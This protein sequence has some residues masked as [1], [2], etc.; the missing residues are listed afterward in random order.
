LFWWSIG[1]DLKIHGKRRARKLFTPRLNFEIEGTISCSTSYENPWWMLSRSVNI[2]TLWRHLMTQ[3]RDII[4]KK[5][6]KCT[7]SPP[8]SMHGWMGGGPESLHARLGEGFCKILLALWVAWFI[9]CLLIVN[10]K[11]F[12]SWAWFIKNILW[13]KK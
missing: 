13:N 3:W 12:I 11:L 1:C 8:K 4:L 6:T 7:C 10:F 2:L 5:K 9:F